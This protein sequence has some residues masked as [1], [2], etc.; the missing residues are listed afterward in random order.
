[1]VFPAASLMVLIGDVAG[2]YQKRSSAPVIE[3]AMA[4]TGAPLAK[5][6]STPAVPTPIPRSTLPE[7]TACSVSPA[8]WVYSSSR[9]RPC[10][11]KNPAFWPSSGAAFSQLPA[12]PDRELEGVLGH[13]RRA[14]RR[15]RECDEPT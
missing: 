11:L 14:D 7:M 8:P 2:T 13:G 10:F 5:A 9:A 1:M 12:L 6:P 4:R 3:L 15:N